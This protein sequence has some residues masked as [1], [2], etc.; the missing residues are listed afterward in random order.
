VSPKIKRAYYIA[1]LNEALKMKGGAPYDPN[2]ILDLAYNFPHY[3]DPHNH[4]LFPAAQ[5]KVSWDIRSTCD[6]CAG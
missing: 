1:G 4:N 6:A 2:H 5:H 3:P